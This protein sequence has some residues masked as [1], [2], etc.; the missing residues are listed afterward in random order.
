VLARKGFHSARVSEI[1]RA[2]GVADGTIY[3]YFKSKEDILIS[4][5][6]GHVGQLNQE[7]RQSVAALPDTSAR[8]A[9]IVRCQVGSLRR[10]RELAEVLSV[11]LRQSNRFLRQFAAP[12]FSEYLDIVAEVIADGQRRGE[13]RED[14]SPL[15]VARALFGA[16]DGLILTW[17]LGRSP[18]G[19]LERAALQVAEVFI[20][21]LRPPATS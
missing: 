7:L 17:A 21:G 11:T 9:H 20:Q 1:A 8:V 12:T 5:F 13:V 10:Q 2:A 6:E 4:L 14:I 19:R 16:L 18:A 3:L 15:V